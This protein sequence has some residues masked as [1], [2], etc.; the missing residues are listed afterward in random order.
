MGVE[1]LLGVIVSGIVQLVKKWLPGKLSVIAIVAFLSLVGATL[2]NYAP[3][4]WEELVR[5]F[6]TA[7]AFYVFVLKHI[8]NE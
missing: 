2:F 7:G 5:V 4:I 1:I 8:Q 6:T 3:S